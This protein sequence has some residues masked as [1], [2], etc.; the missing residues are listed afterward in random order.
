MARGR[1]DAIQLD[2]QESAAAL[3]GTLAPRLL[4]Q[5]AAHGLR[6]RCEKMAAAAPVLNLVDI[7]QTQIGFV[8]QG[9]GLQGLT[10]S[11]LGHSLACRLA[12]LVVY[13]GQQFLGGVRIAL[14]DGG[15]DAGNVAHER[16]PAGQPRRM[17]PETSIM[18]CRRARQCCSSI[19]RDRRK[20][21]ETAAN[22]R[23]FR[24]SDSR[25]QN[26]KTPASLHWSGFFFSF[27][28]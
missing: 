18:T 11:L 22:P 7:Y 10:G 9:G 12:E 21:P 8:Y 20:T 5:D 3:V 23:I 4:D 15:Q 19:C 24:Q 14:F 1:L 26:K 25:S 28:A 6:R 27:D 13:Q 17:E 16:H 2:A